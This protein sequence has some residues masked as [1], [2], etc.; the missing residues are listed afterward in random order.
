MCQSIGSREFSALINNCH[1]SLRQPRPAPAVFY[2]AKDGHFTGTAAGA[3][4]E[5]TQEATSLC[6]TNANFHILMLVLMLHKDKHFLPDDKNLCYCQLIKGQRGSCSLPLRVSPARNWPPLQLNSPGT[7]WLQEGGQWGRIQGTKNH[8]VSGPVK[9]F[10][11]S[12]GPAFQCLYC[13]SQGRLDWC[14]FFLKPSLLYQ[15]SSTEW[16]K[17]HSQMGSAPQ[18]W[19]V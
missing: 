17:G 2:T 13:R 18:L 11:S 12:S 9:V 6:K 10:I 5:Q 14:G 8:C 1:W 7:P 15:P 4:N 19:I 3:R 16:G